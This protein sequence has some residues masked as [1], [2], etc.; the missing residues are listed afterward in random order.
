MNAFE[1]SS[2]SDY[3]EEENPE[4]WNIQ[5]FYQNER[6]VDFVKIP[7]TPEVEIH[8]SMERYHFIIH[9]QYLG[10]L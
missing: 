4:H 7:K 3:I 9:H 1:I 2:L 8:W 5:Y 6:P 10:F